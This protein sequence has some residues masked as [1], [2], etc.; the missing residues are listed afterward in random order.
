[1]LQQIE[2][3]SR[4]P[5]LVCEDQPR[6]FCRYNGIDQREK[7]R[8]LKVQPTAYFLDELDIGYSFCH[9][10][11]LH[12]PALVLQIGPLR[13]RRYAAVGYSALRN[14]LLMSFREI[15]PDRV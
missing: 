3:E 15:D 10:E 9:A 2:T 13:L 12:N 8:S 5:I 4:Q 14:F 7:L 11:F 6:D 1:M